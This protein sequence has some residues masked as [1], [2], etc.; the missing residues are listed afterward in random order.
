[1][2]KFFKL[3]LIFFILPS[4]I[5]A[6]KITLTAD[7]YNLTVGESTIIHIKISGFRVSEIPEIKNISGF[8]LTYIGSSSN[9]TI[10]NGNMKIEKEFNFSLTA[11]KI[12]I[13]NIGPAIIKING[14]ILKSN[15]ITINVTKAIANQNF[16]NFVFLKVDVDKDNVKLNEQIILSLKIYRKI[17][18]SDLDI[19]TPDFNGFIFFKLKKLPEYTTTIGNEVY[20]VTEIRYALFP[21]IAKKIKIGPFIVTGEILNTNFNPFSFQFQIT[22]RFRLISKELVINVTPFNKKN[23]FAV[24]DYTVNANIDKLTVKVGENITYTIRIKGKGNLGLSDSIKFP[25]IKGLNFYYDK[26]KLKITLSSIGVFSEKVQ[27]ILIIPQK[28]GVYKIPKLNLLFY[29][30]DSRKYEKIIIPSRNIKVK[31]SEKEKLIVISKKGKNKINKSQKINKLIFWI[32]LCFL[33]FI[34]LAF[35]IKIF[36]KKKDKKI[37]KSISS[38][39]KCINNSSSYIEI[40]EC[41]KKYFCYESLT[42]NEIIKE[43]LNRG[44]EKDKVEELEKIFKIF[45]KTFYFKKDTQEDLDEIKK[46]LVK[47]FSDET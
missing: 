33:G 9:I 37:V 1:M 28:E 26:P 14:K 39:K 5:Y 47:I 44:Y 21:T 3:F 22:K 41:I 27:T 35:I 15:T 31:K 8:S 12:G 19:K 24:G 25:K 45:E 23:V 30:P 36:P 10:I 7:K 34:V 32:I 13:F 11:K 46:K 43:L 6:D 4:I 16:K 18:I 2:V 29:N 42:F 20:F 40:V 38:L 17:N